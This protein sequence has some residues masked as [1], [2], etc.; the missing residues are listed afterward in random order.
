MKTIGFSRERVSLGKPIPWSN[1]P[2]TLDVFFVGSGNAFA[3]TDGRGECNLILGHRSRLCALD[4]GRQWIERVK[5]IARLGVRDI[6]EVLITHA[7]CDHTGSLAS[8]AERRRY[9]N[10]DLAVPRLVA[11][12]NVISDL[13]GL[14]LVPQIGKHEV[15]IG[16]DAF[17]EVASTEN[18]D[19]RSV[20]SYILGGVGIELFRTMHDPAT[21]KSW[22]DSAFSTGVFIPAFGLWIS[23]DTRY[24][25][26]LA[27][28][29]AARG[30][31][32]FLHD[33]ARNGAVHASLDEVQSLNGT[34]A[35]T[36]FM[37]TPD[38]ILDEEAL[39]LGFLGV[40]EPGDLLR[41]ELCSTI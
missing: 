40:A 41:L 28:S 18:I 3:D 14:E 7:H 38:D 4:M 37:H 9:F 15:G 21:A 35:S 26:G 12:P 31:E 36:L 5:R 30:A 8:Y 20:S 24:E 13:L 22:R 6:S 17:F 27:E 23:G 33:V 34:K 32:W 25:P 11:H 16:A 1:S 19:E 29:Y 10:R 39:L 2:L